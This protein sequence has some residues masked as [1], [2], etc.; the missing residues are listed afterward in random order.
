V[1][2]TCNTAAGDIAC[3]HAYAGTAALQTQ[4]MLQSRLIQGVPTGRAQ[5]IRQQLWRVSCQPAVAASSKSFAAAATAAGV[6]S[7][8]CSSQVQPTHAAAA[9]AADRRARTEPLLHRLKS[10]RGQPGQHINQTAQ[11]HC[12]HTTCYVQ[13]IP[14][15]ASRSCAPEKAKLVQGASGVS[16]LCLPQHH[17]LKFTMMPG[18]H[19]QPPLALTTMATRHL[20][21][22]SLRLTCC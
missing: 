2:E 7:L 3:Q 15:Q 17:L 13:C 10:S 18:W 1:G 11:H 16:W 9:A 8:Q 21:T 14:S 4:S 22:S 20:S 6:Q 5:L 12:Y 19:C